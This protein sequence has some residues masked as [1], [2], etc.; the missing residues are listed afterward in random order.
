[1]TSFPPFPFL[2]RQVLRLGNLSKWRWA[3]IVFNRLGGGF[4]VI[5][6]TDGFK[7]YGVKPQYVR[8]LVPAVADDLRNRSDSEADGDPAAALTLSR[9]VPD[10]REWGRTK[11]SSV[12]AAAV[13][14]VHEA[15]GPRTGSKQAAATGPGPGADVDSKSGTSASTGPTAAEQRQRFDRDMQRYVEAI[16]GRIRQ[17]R[18]EERRRRLALSAQ[19]A[20]VLQV[21]SSSA[22]SLSLCTPS[23]P[24]SFPPSL[25]LSLPHTHTADLAISCPFY[26]LRLFV[27]ST[28]VSRFRSP[29]AS[30]SACV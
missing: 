9:V 7:E 20:L 26:Y 22:H 13:E 6:E 17:H 19:C 16:A 25:S 4:D 21:R 5:Y 15:A 14:V 18:A 3:K 8:T 29:T 12:V 2:L 27:G 11:P 10:G 24:P 30:L 28:L 1:M 23:L